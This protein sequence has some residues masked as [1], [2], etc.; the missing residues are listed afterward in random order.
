MNAYLEILRP[1]NALLAVVAVVL[2]AIIGK[3]YDVP[4]LIGII[5]VFLATGAGN[6]INDYFDYK[7][8]AINKPERPI[9]SGR[10]SLKNARN[11]S[12]ILFLLAIALGS[13]ISFIINSYWPF[14]I[15]VFNSIVMYYYAYSLKSSVLTGN[16]SVAFL[17]A[18][19]FIFGGSIIGLFE[20]SFYLA[21]FAF[22]MTLAREIVK[23]MEDY[24]GDKQEG[25][26]TLPIK[27][28]MKISS[29][30]AALFILLASCLSP[31]LYLNGIFNL[32]YLIPLTIALIFFIMSAYKI[33]LNQEVEN[34]KTVSKLLKRG[35]MIAFIAFAVG[36]F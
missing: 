24:I 15:V 27:Y 32:Y 36:S 13:I 33:L 23:D 18:S 8:D 19:C 12:F 26:K 3:N 4:I 1:G 7:I 17:T 21:F 34:C 2:I 9:P 22:F 20:I 6:V 31:I 11:Y 14:I 35:M 16:I 30:L 5:T 29:I 28:G 10:I 25:A